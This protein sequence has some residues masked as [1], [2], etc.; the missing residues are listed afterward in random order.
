MSF[1]EEF[2][3]GYEF[4]ILRWFNVLALYFNFS[5][6]SR[7]LES[8]WL[9]IEE[10]LLDS[11]LVTAYIEGVIVI[12]AI[13]NRIEVY[14]QVF[15][16]YH[17]NLHNFIDSFPNIKLSTVLPKLTLLQLSIIKDVIY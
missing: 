11:L 9:Q 13:E 15:C 3:M 2:L 12:K 14:L 6:S 17:L 7:E 8:I 5:A 1:S 16:L 10:D 4:Q